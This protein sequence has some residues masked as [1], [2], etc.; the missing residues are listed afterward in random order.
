MCWMSAQESGVADPRFANLN[1]RLFQS[2]VSDVFCTG[3]C[4]EPKDNL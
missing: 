1:C 4:A 2:P 3:T